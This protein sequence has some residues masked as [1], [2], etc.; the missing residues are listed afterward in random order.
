[1]DNTTLSEKFHKV[2]ICYTEI[3]S[4]I[5]MIEMWIYDKL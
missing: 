3:K 2:S 1:M 5:F 4:Q